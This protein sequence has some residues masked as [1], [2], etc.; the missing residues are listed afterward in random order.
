M[1]TFSFIGVS[2]LFVVTGCG[3]SHSSTDEFITVDVNESIQPKELYC[4]DLHGIHS[5]KQNDSL[6]IRDM[7]VGCENI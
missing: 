4:V 1:K 5:Q 3:G 2:I 6:I 7:R